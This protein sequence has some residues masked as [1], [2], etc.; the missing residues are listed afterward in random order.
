ML[1]RNIDPKT[2]LCNVTRLLCREF[3]KN[4]LD[5]K[6]LTDHN[7]Q[8]RVFLPKIKHKTTESTRFFFILIRK[9]FPIK[10]NFAITINKSQGQTIP[11]VRI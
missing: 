5:V 9:Q 1:L 8:K 2:S 3:F 10:L 4:M 6:I 7:A 11:N